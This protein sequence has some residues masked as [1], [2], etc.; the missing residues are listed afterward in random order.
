MSLCNY[1]V[2]LH[3]QFN[4]DKIHISTIYNFSNI[5]LGQTQFYNSYLFS[6]LEDLHDDII[7]IIEVAVYSTQINETDHEILQYLAGVYSYTHIW[8]HILL[9]LLK[10][11]PFS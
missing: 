10:I 9:V 5:E 6:M 4:K 7:I 1:I 2:G 8:L 3:F 11:N